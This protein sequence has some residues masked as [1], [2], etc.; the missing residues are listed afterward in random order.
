MDLKDRFDGGDKI[1]FSRYADINVI[2]GAVKLYL[3]ELPIPL[4]TFD[5]Y[6]EIMKA[7]SKQLM[8]ER[9][10]EGG[11]REI[12]RKGDY[13]VESIQ[14]FFVSSGTITDPKE[15]GVDW[16]LLANAL[17]LLPK[18]HYNTLKYLVEHLRRYIH[19]Y[20]SSDMCI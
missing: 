18:A 13:R 5:V 2:C 7:T 19:M 16:S 1:D 11:G 17:K 10:R 4:V 3:R 14:M 9:E 6:N 15:E 20:I 8:G 12:D